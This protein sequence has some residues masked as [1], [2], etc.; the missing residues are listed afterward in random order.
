MTENLY[1]LENAW[2]LAIRRE[3]D[4]HDFYARMAR[5]ASD[6]AVRAFFE[7]L[8][9]EE[10]RHKARLEDEFRRAF[11]PDLEEARDRTGTFVHDFH[12]G[13]Q[14]PGF[15]W[16]EWED[17]AFRLAHEL[18]VPILLDISASWCHWCHVMDEKTYSH[19][20]VAALINAEFIPIRV[21]TD[22]RPDINRR[23]NM[24]GWPTT[25]FLT[26]D[27][28]VLTGGT[29]LT[30]PQFLDV[31]RK[32]SEYYRANKGR[33]R[34][35]LE[36][37]RSDVAAASVAGVT[38]EDLSLKI[39][40]DA[41]SILI[42]GF[43][44]ENGGFGT[45]PKFPMPE[46]LELAL[47]EYPRSG[48]EQLRAIVEK[49]LRAMASGGMY[50]PVEGGFFRYSTTRDWSIPHYE[51]MAEDNAKL[52]AVYTHAYQVFGDPFYRDVAAD[53]VRYILRTLTDE[54][55]FFYASQDAD[56]EYYKLGAA[57]RARRKPPYV[58]KTPYTDYNAMLISALLHAGV[59]L[60]D[61]A[62]TDAALR[63]VDAIWERHYD[64]ARGMAH[65][66]G[67]QGEVWGLLTDPIW[68]AHALL[69]AH[70]FTSEPRFLERA[71][72]V[73]EFVYAH[74][75][76]DAGG[77]YD[78]VDDPNAL[79]KLRD[80]DKPITDNAVAAYA[81]LRLHA[82]TGDERHRE[83]AGKALA[84]FGEVYK[85]YGYFASGYAMAVAAYLG[86]PIQAIIVGSADDART[87]DLRQAA[88]R[89][90]A[91]YRVIQVVDPTW[92]RERLARLGYPAEPAPR[93]YICVGL[94]CAQPT[95]RP[96]AVAGIVQPL[97]SPWRGRTPRDS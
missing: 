70:E 41:V 62:P 96:E 65:T 5:S 68:M 40:E 19:P 9:E 47:A 48:A 4:A 33:I 67:P 36:E 88:L 30:V 81:A 75:Q 82:F 46:S 97:V 89:V 60:D 39:V 66:R 23:Y 93:A 37:L 86:Q 31:A 35:R 90:Y 22:K 25:A 14:P 50:D 11:Q 52:L 64:E 51:K 76:N 85:A 38:T 3:Q 73:M 13:H 49:T 32:V 58:D 71:V 45:E 7:S 27:G 79:G 59:V 87:R 57:E 16:W 28:E 21:D 91:P 84:W 95:D 2:K 83:A 24:G 6:A 1:E 34:E 55:G 26:P 74:L 77:F 94:T 15:S 53:V 18:D 10:L 8:A 80:R 92:E 29:Y 63:A 12:R 42:Q 72:R 20:E 56:E 54:R 78:R 69:D 44:K 17:E 43:D 61:R